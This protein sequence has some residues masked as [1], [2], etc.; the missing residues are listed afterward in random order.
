MASLFSSRM[1]EGRSLNVR[2][3]SERE[4]FDYVFETLCLQKGVSG[5]LLGAILFG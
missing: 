2:S 4:R 1:T 5:F 3:C